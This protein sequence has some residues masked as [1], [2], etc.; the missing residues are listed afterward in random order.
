MAENPTSFELPNSTVDGECVDI[1]DFLWANSSDLTS[2]PGVMGLFA[3]V[4][5]TIVLISLLGNSLVILSVCQHKSLQS[6]RNLFIVSLSVSDIVIS[7]VSGTITVSLRNNMIVTFN[8]SADHG[9]YKNLA[10]RRVVVPLG[11]RPSR[12]FTLLLNP[13]TD[14]HFH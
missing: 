1:K 2:L 11:A 8:N 7:V 14:F 9:I 12:G 5:S 13:D 4:Y 10:F 3:L 6:V